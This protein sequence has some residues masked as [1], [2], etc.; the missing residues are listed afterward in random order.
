MPSNQNEAKIAEG[1]FIRRCK[2]ITS[3]GSQCRDA[4]GHDGPCGALPGMPFV[5]LRSAQ[6]VRR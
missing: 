3:F 5:G 4:E 2:T 6:E 1:L